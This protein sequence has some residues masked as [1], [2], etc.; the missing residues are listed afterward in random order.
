[1]LTEAP[2][3]YTPTDPRTHVT[4]ALANRFELL[5]EIG[6]GGMAVVY[7]ARQKNLDRIVSW[8]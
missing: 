2:P 1:M 4:L 8:D 5:E 3:T 6:K 7:K